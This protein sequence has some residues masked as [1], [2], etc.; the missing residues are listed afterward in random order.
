MQLQVSVVCRGNRFEAV[1]RVAAFKKLQRA[2]AAKYNI[3]LYPNVLEKTLFENL[4]HS[5]AVIM[6]GI[7]SVVSPSKAGKNCLLHMPE[8]FYRRV[9]VST[10]DRCLSKRVGDNTVLEIDTIESAEMLKL[11]FP[12]MEMTVESINN[13]LEKWFKL[14]PDGYWVSARAGSVLHFTIKDDSI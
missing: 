8:V 4:R 11:D 14:F 7:E 1:N 13:F 12:E 2:M 5:G 9:S 6:D 3:P 10:I